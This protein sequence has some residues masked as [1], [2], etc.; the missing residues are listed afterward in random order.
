MIKEVKK[1]MENK[2][3]QLNNMIKKSNNIVFFGGAA[4]DKQSGP[5]A[6]KTGNTGGSQAHNNVQPYIVTYMWKRVA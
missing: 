6:F 4:S 1:K 3:E 5:N 2:I